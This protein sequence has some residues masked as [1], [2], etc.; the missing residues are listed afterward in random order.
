MK[1]HTVTKQEL[2]EI[3]PVT[4]LCSSSGG[5]DSVGKRMFLKVFIK[6]DGSLIHHYEVIRKH[7]DGVHKSV[8]IG[9]NLDLAVELYNIS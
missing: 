8:Y 7:S 3:K 4:V 6:P 1:N 5:S 9:R 2:M